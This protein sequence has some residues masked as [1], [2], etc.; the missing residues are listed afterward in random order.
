MGGWVDILTVN[1]D[2]DGRLELFVRGADGAVWHKW[3][4]A[5]NNGWSGWA[6][7]GG[8]VDIVTVDQNAA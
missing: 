2:A 1:Q 6:S 4:T 7:M 8:W 5:P 3:Q